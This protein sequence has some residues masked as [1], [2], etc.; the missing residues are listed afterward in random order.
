MRERGCRSEREREAAGVREC[1]AWLA[2]AP[3]SGMEM[4]QRAALQR[5]NCCLVCILS[6]RFKGLNVST[7][8]SL[9]MDQNIVEKQ[10]NIG[11]QK[12]GFPCLA[13]L[14]FRKREVG[15]QKQWGD[16]SQ[17]YLHFRM[18]M[19]GDCWAGCG[20]SLRSDALRVILLL[21]KKPSSAIL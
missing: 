3:K 10:S 14:N 9:N 18:M 7:E 17:E 1:A 5:S 20:K 4:C 16:C 11:N 21:I 12:K 15:L 13:S 6:E 8:H 19:S 2:G